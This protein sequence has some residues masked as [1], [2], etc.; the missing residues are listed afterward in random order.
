MVNRVLVILAIALA[1]TFGVTACGGYDDS[2]DDDPAVE[3]GIYNGG[4]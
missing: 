2:Y 1:A 3:Q 4:Y